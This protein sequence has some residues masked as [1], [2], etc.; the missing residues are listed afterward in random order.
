MRLPG[1]V[2]GMFAPLALVLHGVSIEKQLYWIVPL[3]ALAFIGQG[4]KVPPFVC[5]KTIRRESWKLPIIRPLR[6]AVERKAT[7]ASARYG[8]AACM[9]DRCD[10]MFML[11]QQSQSSSSTLSRAQLRP[12]AVGKDHVQVAPEHLDGPS[13]KAETTVLSGGKTKNEK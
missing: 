1:M 4:G 5:G 9:R 7:I 12:A 2:D 8:R 11:K 3:S 10:L 6:D 13:G